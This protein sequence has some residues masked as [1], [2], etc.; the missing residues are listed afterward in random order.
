[1]AKNPDIVGILEQLAAIVNPLFGGQELAVGYFEN[2]LG[3]GGSSYYI[4][5]HYFISLCSDD[6]RL[7]LPL[8][9]QRKADI[10][11]IFDR[12]FQRTGEFPVRV[13]NNPLVVGHAKLTLLEISEVYRRDG[14]D[15]SFSVETY[16]LGEV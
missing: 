12:D 1:M 11:K 9:S 8:S 6:S 7:R 14:L 16:G 10:L 4:P 3:T 13:L 2:E 15:V 5:P